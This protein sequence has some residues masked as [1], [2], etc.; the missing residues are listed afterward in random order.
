LKV[1]DNIEEIH[2]WIRSHKVLNHTIGFVPTMGA[3]H[4][5]HISLVRRS[6]AENDVTIVS[7]F[8]NPLQ[9]GV[10]EDL[11]KYPRPLEEDIF[12]LDQCGVDLCFHPQASE[13]LGED[14]QTF[15]DMQGLPEHLCGLKRPGHFRGACTIVAKLFN[16]V[17]PDRAYFGRKDLQQ[18]FIIQKMVHD[19]NF[20]IEIVPCPIVREKD[21]LAMSSRNLY[22]SSNERKDAAILS[23]IIKQAAESS[24]AGCD[25]A[26]LTS[27]LR[28]TVAAVA[29]ARI[30]YI[31]IVD[32]SLEDVKFVQKGDILV[33][34]V[35]IGGTRLID[36]YIFGESLNF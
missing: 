19:L 29:S 35:Y 14:L 2:E 30:D 4:E 34:A 25:A 1:H 24:W 9:F 27:R 32:K 10:N 33:L 5:G 16:I 6:I 12:L 7:I 18:L 36:N 20:P 17:S 31:Q 28:E 21:G 11:Q 22:L 13:L 8:V 15:V 26:E 23:R 3:L